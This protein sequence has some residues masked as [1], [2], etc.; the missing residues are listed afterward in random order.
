MWLGE[1]VIGLHSHAPGFWESSDGGAT[2]VRSIPDS[3]IT[4]WPWGIQLMVHDD[5][6]IVVTGT[7]DLAK[8]LWIG[9]IG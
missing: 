3:T 2:W 9:T 4:P 1:T 6:A 7:N 8:S 5:V